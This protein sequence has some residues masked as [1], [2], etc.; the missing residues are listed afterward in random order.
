MMDNETIESL[1]DRLKMDDSIGAFEQQ[2]IDLDLLLEMGE[3]ELKDTL[4][5]L[6]LTI[7]KQK[8]ICLEIKRL[9]SRK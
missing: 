5:E 3:E 4:K 6:K 9:K 2:D 8:K 1:L 7:G